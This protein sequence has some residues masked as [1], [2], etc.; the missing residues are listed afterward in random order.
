[1]KISYGPPAAR[2][3]TQ[4]MAVGAADFDPTPVDRAVARGGL[5]ALAV[6]G[7][8]LVTGN[9]GARNFGLGAAVAL[10]GVRMVSRPRAVEVTAPAPAPAAGYFR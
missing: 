6:L 10:Y 9:R 4:L 1:M 7:F 5:L 2:G 8:G 3:V